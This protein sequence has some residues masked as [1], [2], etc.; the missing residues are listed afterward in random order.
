MTDAPNAPGA[1]STP[2]AEN[3]ETGQPG[4]VSKQL[5]KAI[6]KVPYVGSI[7]GW[8]ILHGYIGSVVLLLVVFVVIPLATPLLSAL[9]IGLLPEKLRVAYAT[10]V[11]DA[12]SVDTMIQQNMDDMLLQN[13]SRLDFVQQFTKHWSSPTDLRS[14]FFRFPLIEGQKFAVDFEAYTLAKAQER[15]CKNGEERTRLADA[16]ANSEN[17]FQV[18][19]LGAE[20]FTDS[21]T[22]EQD[23][24][25]AWVFTDQFWAN[26]KVH[27]ALTQSEGY[28]QVVIDRV[29]GAALLA[30]YDVTA[31][32]RIVVYKT[33]SSKKAANAAKPAAKAS[34][35][36]AGG[37][38]E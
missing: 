4:E 24:P 30:C 1:S 13:N 29:Q 16:A 25:H 31:D 11:T 33:I 37:K 18:K 27:A 5:A 36:P 9:Y 12:Y 15:G 3:A 20:L 19:V 6:E 10:T 23:H 14:Q 28:A 35:A 21:I 7:L 34:E 38:K 8:L 26:P 22:T 2:R 17:L 32:L